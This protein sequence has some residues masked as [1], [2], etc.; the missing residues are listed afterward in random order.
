MVSLKEP[1]GNTCPQINNMQKLL[2]NLINDMGYYARKD[3]FFRGEVTDSLSDWTSE[4]NSISN[5]LEDLR[6]ANSAL[7]D[8]GNE[9]VN[10]VE[11]ITQ[12]ADKTEGEL[13]DEIYELEY[14]I[15]HEL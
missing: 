7:R 3:E 13:R 5:D 12:E 6:N 10:A 11:E 2:S 9:L 1:I 14:K 4:L 15:K 8:W